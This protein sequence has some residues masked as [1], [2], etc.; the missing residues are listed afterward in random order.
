MSAARQPGE[1]TERVVPRRGRPVASDGGAHEAIVEAAYRLIRDIGYPN[2]TVDDVIRAAGVSRASFYF[3]FQNKKH[4]LLELSRSVME[5]LYEVAGRHYPDKDQYSRIVLANVSYLDVWRR[6]TAI[7]GEFF[8]L[9]LVDSE[10]AAIY[11]EYR[12]RFE[13]R[14][15]ERISHLRDQE[16]IPDCNP[17]VLAGVLSSMVEFSAFRHFVTDDAIGHSR[18]SFSDLVKQLSEAWYGAVYGA[19]PPTGFDHTIFE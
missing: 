3:Y 6:E 12:E 5:E 15:R 13:V 16:R 14:I 17:A 9:S 11:G 1:S 10:L 18:I 8:A 2:L 7:L 19:A 4:L